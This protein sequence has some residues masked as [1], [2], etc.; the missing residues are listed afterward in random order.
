MEFPHRC[1]KC[2]AE[3]VLETSYP[4]RVDKQG[5]HVTILTSPPRSAEQLSV[6]RRIAEYYKDHVPSVKGEVDI[7][8]SEM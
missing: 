2:G 5:N 8:Y 4:K 7:A 1:N 6:Q 3:E